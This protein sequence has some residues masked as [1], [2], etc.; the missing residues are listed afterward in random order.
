VTRGRFALRM[1][2]VTESFPYIDIYTIPDKP[3][4]NSRGMDASLTY[5]SLDTLRQLWDKYS[6]GLPERLM[7]MTD[8]QLAVDGP[9]M[10]PMGPTLMDSI[11]FIAIHESYHIGQMGTLRR[12]LGYDAMSFR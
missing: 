4:P 7:Q 11:A 3:M 6:D 2:L 12:S 9:F 10:T 1:G 8:E 5:P